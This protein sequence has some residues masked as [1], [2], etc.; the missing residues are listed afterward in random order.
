MQPDSRYKLQITRHETTRDPMT[1]H[2][3]TRHPMTRDDTPP[4]DS[5]RDDA[6]PVTEI[7]EIE[8]A[9]QQVPKS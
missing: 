8:P 3:T 6:P 1:C 9:E 7:S 5:P 2:E 4:D